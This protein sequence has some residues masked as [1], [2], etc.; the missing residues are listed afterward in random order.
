MSCQVHKDDKR[1]FLLLRSP[2]SGERGRLFCVW[3]KYSREMQELSQVS[4]MRNGWKERRKQ[5]AKGGAQKPGRALQ[6]GAFPKGEQRICFVEL[7][8]KKKPQRMMQVSDK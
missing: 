2:L 1:W 6:H 4:C 3:L 7:G 5:K 8:G